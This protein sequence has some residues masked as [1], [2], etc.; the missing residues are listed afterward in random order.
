MLATV[1]GIVARQMAWRS[2]TEDAGSRFAVRGDLGR[3]APVEPTAARIAGAHGL[4]VTRPHT[5]R[6]AMT[7]GCRGPRLAVHEDT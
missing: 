1:S 5:R 6:R 3:A 2:G 7:A 4:T